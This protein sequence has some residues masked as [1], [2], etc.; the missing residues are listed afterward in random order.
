MQTI[1]VKT[2]R[3]IRKIGPKAPVFIIAEISGNHNHSIKR[4]YKIIDAAAKAKVDAVKLQTYTA[5]TLTIDCDNKYFQIR[6]N[7]AWKGQTLH[8]LYQKAYTPWEW[9]PKLKKYAESKGLLCFSTPF[10]ETAVDFLEKMD[11]QLYK[12]ASFEIIDI[13]LLEKIGKTR[14]PVI[15]SRGMASIPEINLA[16]NTLR[17]NGCP[18]IALLHCVSAYPAKSEEMNLLTIPDIQKRFNVITGLSDHTLGI[19]AAIASVSLG[20]SI[21]EK[22]VTLC[23][24]DGGPDAGFSLEPGE[25]K[26]MVDGIQ[27][28]EKSLGKPSYKVGSDESQ[29]IVF[30][31][32]LFAVK[33]IEKGAKITRDNVRSIRPGHGLAPKYL[34]TIINKKSIRKIKR[35]TPLTRDLIK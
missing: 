29:N 4:A 14:K 9:Q 19:N 25:L 6:T 17:I 3:G 13:P 10:D 16:L 11:V 7:K 34:S 12:I 20:A 35:G 33:D 28:V 15:M 1:T 2:P 27:D 24:A 23:H 30:R 32:S 8:S 22:H 21:I 18:Q 5:D 26:K 31:R